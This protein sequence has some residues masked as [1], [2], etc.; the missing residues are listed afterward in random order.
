MGA[1]VDR[2]HDEDG[3]VLPPGQDERQLARP[4]CL[5]LHLGQE[6]PRL[7]ASV[8][9][10][11]ARRRE[12]GFNCVIESV[13]QRF[14]LFSSEGVPLR[15]TLTVGLKEYKTVQEQLGEAQP[16]VR[17]PDAL[18]HAAPG[19]DADRR[20]QHRLR[21][22]DRVAADRRPQ[23][24]HRP[25]GGRR[26]LHPRDPASPLMP[27]QPIPAL[28]SDN[29]YEA[30]YRPSFE[31]TITDTRSCR[32]TETGKPIYDKVLHDIES[33]S[34]VDNVEEADSFTLDDHELGCRAP[35]AEVLRLPGEAE[36]RRRQEVLDVLRAVRP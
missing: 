23:Q 27:V 31:I 5:P 29:P 14:S 30:F 13:R 28:G 15:A 3:Q 10:G 34:Y 33:V 22:P 32:R 11:R 16:S 7:V 26:R 25:A 6:L 35:E 20:R 8:P 36:Q 24:R 2:R 12:H 19:R 21:R 1:N 9:T 17:R 4:T 18:L